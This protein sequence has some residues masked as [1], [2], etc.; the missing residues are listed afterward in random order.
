LNLEDKVRLQGKG[1][2]G[3]VTSEDEVVE[4]RKS[5]HGRKPNPKYND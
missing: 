2:D 1:I 4:R 5:T 3:V